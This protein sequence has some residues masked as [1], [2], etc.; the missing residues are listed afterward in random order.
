MGTFK[1]SEGDVAIVVN[2]GVY[3]QADIYIRDGMLYAAWG[4]GF[5]RIKEDGSTSQATARVDHLDFE[6]EIHRD[7]MGRLCVPSTDRKS[8]PI[9]EDRR[10]LL[11]GQS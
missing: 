1:Q 2:K 4:G 11:I 5:I 9:G 6:G 8:V 3:K 10:Q 7:E